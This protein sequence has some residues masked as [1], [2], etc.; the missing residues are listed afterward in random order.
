MG[1]CGP[2]KGASAFRFSSD[3]GAWLTFEVCLLAG[4]LK[5]LEQRSGFAAALSLA[6][7]M[8][9]LFLTSEWFT[10][11]GRR[12]TTVVWDNW[13][14]WLLVSVGGVL[15]TVGVAL[16]PGH[17]RLDLAGAMVLWGLFAGVILWMRMRLAVRDL[18]VLAASAVLLTG[19]ALVLGILAFDGS[20][21]KVLGYW[22]LWAWFFPWSIFYM[23]TWL[24]GNTLPRWRIWVASL[25]FFMEAAILA[26][27]SGWLASLFLL[28]LCGRV[29]WRLKRR[30]R[31]FDE[32]NGMPRVVSLARDV[33]LLGYEQMVW[34][35]VLGGIWVVG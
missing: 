30:L 16:A 21:G 18:R 26:C 1:V 20:G 35:F 4:L 32:D 34:T 29:I 8:H 11:L 7:G 22:S 2:I 14:V 25:A 31:E 23:Q 13:G 12:E 24:R 15:L 3:Y 19:P 5:V 17:L 27:F 10:G 6:A 28:P 9:A 33:R